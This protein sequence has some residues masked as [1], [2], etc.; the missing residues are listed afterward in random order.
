M[1]RA[2]LAIIPVLLDL[3]A[4]D[5]WH[6]VE[7]LQDHHSVSFLNRFGTSKDRGHLQIAIIFHLLGMYDEKDVDVIL[8]G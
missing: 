7:L 3:N 8:G 6:I 4:S 5:L 2:E 1:V